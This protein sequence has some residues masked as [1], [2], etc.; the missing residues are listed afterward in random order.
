MKT[1]DDWKIQAKQ[2]IRAE[3]KRRSLSYA[4]L[5]TRMQ[6]IGLAANERTVANKIAAGGFSAAFFLQ[7]MEAIGVKAIY[8]TGE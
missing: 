7:C 1:T 3:M 8:L 6:G 4:D 2:L 5:A